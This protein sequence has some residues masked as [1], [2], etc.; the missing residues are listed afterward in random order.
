MQLF[1]SFMHPPVST[2]YVLIMGPI[3]HTLSQIYS[4]LKTTPDGYK[5]SYI[6]NREDDLLSKLLT[7]N[8]TDVFCFFLP[9]LGPG[10]F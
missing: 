4:T 6:Q 1:P 2:S 3:R 8:N 7:Q 5:P 10:V 9:V